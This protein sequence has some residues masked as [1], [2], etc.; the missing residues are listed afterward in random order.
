M[1]NDP[2]EER[3][4]RAA[5]WATVAAAVSPPEFAAD[6]PTRQAAPDV[7]GY[8]VKGALPTQGPQS[9]AFTPAERL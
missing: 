3:S 1:S 8:S 6:D 5:F 7:G 4:G 9:T 2:Y